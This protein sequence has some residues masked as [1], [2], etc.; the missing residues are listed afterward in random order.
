MRLLL[1][2]VVLGA[3]LW[4]GYWAVAARGLETGLAAWVEARRAEGWAAD[5]AALEVAGFPTRFDIAFD[6]LMLAD[7]DTGLAWSAPGFRIEAAAHRPNRI[8]AIWPKAQQIATPAEKI[9]I[10]A[11]RMEG[12]LAFRPGPALEV[13]HASYVL[14]QV[15]LASTLGWQASM[16]Q[17]ELGSAAV[18]GRK[19]AHRIAFSAEE[20]RPPARLVAL[21]DR[22]G[23]LPALFEHVRIEA[24]LDFDAPWDRHAIEDRRPQ[25]TRIELGGL[26]AKWGDLELRAAG[27]LDVDAEGL[28]AGLLTVRAT[29]WREMVAIARG[30]GRLP[31]G[32]AD[33]VEDALGL[34]AGLGGR[35]ETLDIPLRFAAG[36]TWLGP[37]P[38]GPA[39]DFTIR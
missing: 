6:G 24:V 36:Q 16:A 11:A 25:I 39:P 22:A 28:P 5:Y 26:D 27:D 18:E 14:D 15:S 34:L 20:M 12:Q 38:V 32:L 19:N 4:S 23:V 8:T 33:R 21:L 2:L 10:G 31:P 7:P 3:A 17:A 30:S 9:A 29:N 37:V 35:P 13:A 1:T